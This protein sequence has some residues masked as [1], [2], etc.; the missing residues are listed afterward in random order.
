MSSI[1]FWSRLE[2]KSGN[3]NFEKSL[4]AQIRDPLWMLARQWQFGEF[5]GDDAGSP[6]LV[7]LKT[8]KTPITHIR[9]PGVEENYEPFNHETTPLEINVEKESRYSIPYYG[10]EIGD[11]FK[12]QSIHRV[13]DARTSAEMG[14]WY[15]SELESLGEEWRTNFLSAFPFPDPDAVDVDEGATTSFDWDEVDE[16]TRDF[17][18]AM[19]GRV[20]DGGRLLYKLMIDLEITGETTPTREQVKQLL[21][22]VDDIGDDD[23]SSIGSICIEFISKYKDK[24]QL[25]DNLEQG[26]SYWVPERLEY[27]FGIVTQLP[28]SNYFKL[29]APEYYEG[30]LDWYSFT[31]AQ[32]II[33]H[34]DE[35]PGELLGPLEFIPTPVMFSG[36]PNSRW[37]E[38][39]EGKTNFGGMEV[40]KTDLAKLLLMEFALIH[41]NDWFLSPL[42]LEMGNLYEIEYLLVRDIFGEWTLIPLAGEGPHVKWQN[43]W[44]MFKLSIEEKNDDV[45]EAPYLFLP[46]TLINVMESKPI[47]KVTFFRDEMANMV[48]AVEQILPNGMGEPVSGYELYNEKIARIETKEA[49]KSS[50]STNKQKELYQIKYRLQS[51]IPDNWI[52]FIPK[53]KDNEPESICLERA[54]MLREE[55]TGELLPIP[56]K[57]KILTPLNKDPYRIMEEEIRRTGVTITRTV[58]RA[59]W[60]DGKTHIWVGRRKRPG[61]GEGYSSLKF[62]LLIDTNE[63]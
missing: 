36:M 35:K 33:E 30:D 25:S 44:S 18:R 21:P 45:S 24:F 63:T 47:E 6:S 39:E 61:R 43:K 11:E 13:F 41:G 17:F 2:P 46:S 29:N 60:I 34:L 1:T 53:L 48:W 19:Q 23:A 55:N 4:Q 20:I 12:T 56:P 8:R 51:T 27:N 38:F 42:P 9:T 14:L 32:D 54:A 10:S 58:Q 49:A 37:W 57:G 7:K 3:G 50:E 40:R 5:Q 52:P 28:D 26:K 62:D 59:R 15:L 22:L 16:A 31:V